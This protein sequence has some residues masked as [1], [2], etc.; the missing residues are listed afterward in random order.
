MQSNIENYFKMFNMWKV[1]EIADKVTN[2]VMNYTEIEAK[3]REATND[4][5]W[6]PTGQLMQEVA[7]GTFSYEHFPEVMCMLWKRMLQD[8]KSNWRRTYKSLLLLNYLIRNGSERVVSSS[9]EHIYDLRSLEN[10]TFLDDLGKDQGINIR[11]KVKELIDFIQ[12]DERLREERKKAKKN[13]D[14]YVGL[15]SDGMGLR[16]GRERWEESTEWGGDKQPS[17]F[18]DSSNNSDDGEKYDSDAEATDN[19]NEPSPSRSPAVYKDKGPITLKNLNRPGSGSP[20]KVV[21]T[22]KKIDLGAA[23]GYS[24]G[25]GN[26]NAAGSSVTNVASYGNNNL[27]LF[28]DFNPRAG[29]ASDF[30]NFAS[31]APVSTKPSSLPSS[32][33]GRGGDGGD[34]ADFT[35][36]FSDNSAANNGNVFKGSGGGSIDLIHNNFSITPKNSNTDLLMGLTPSLP[37]NNIEKDLL[38]SGPGLSSDFSSMG[39]LQPSGISL[40]QPMSASSASANVPVS[41]SQSSRNVQV[42]QTWSN[43]GNVNIDIDNLSLSGSKGK[44]KE[45]RTSMNQLASNSPTSPTSRQGSAFG[46]NQPVRNPNF[47]SPLQ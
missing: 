8:N 7:Q 2:V 36:A 17:G 38:S 44:Q 45:Q 1:R 5:A 46:M 18:H 14:K 43:A 13:K 37:R 47:F 3:V 39:S 12:D 9:R 11:H 35:S 41:S 34:F 31:V 19:V 42:G 29:E 6:G 30:G 10:Y 40:L 33:S 21:K 15:S 16:S 25:S 23:A 32:S 20:A 27:D 26:S 22:V 24:A 4:D 28:D